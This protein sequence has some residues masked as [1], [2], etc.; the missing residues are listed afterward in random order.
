M[1]SSP[2]TAPT[3]ALDAARAVLPAGIFERI[4]PYAERLDL[5]LITRAYEFSQ[6]AHAGQKRHSGQDY[7]VHCER[8]AEILA[9]L[10]LD[11]V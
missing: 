11:S 2:A 4:E 5:G 7:I 6:V 9:E 3:S 10:H 1:A 8:V